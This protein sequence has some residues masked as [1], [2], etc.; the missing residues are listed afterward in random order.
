MGAG[1][2]IYICMSGKFIITNLKSKIG[3]KVLPLHK[4]PLILFLR[5]LEQ[6]CFKLLKHVL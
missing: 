6:L 2:K 3:A 1:K 5:L 4:E